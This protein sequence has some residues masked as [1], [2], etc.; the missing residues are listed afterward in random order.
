MLEPTAA[1]FLAV[2]ET[3]TGKDGMERRNRDL[4]VM[5]VQSKRAPADDDYPHHGGQLHDAEGFIAGFVDALDIGAPEVRGDSDGD[6]HG[7]PGDF[8]GVGGIVENDG[9]GA[10]LGEPEHDFTEQTQD[11]LPGSDGADRACEHVIEHQCAD[12]Q[13]GEVSTDGAFDDLVHTAAGEHR[14]AFDI[15]RTHGIAEEHDPENEP[16][17]GFADGLLADSTDVVGGACQIAEHDGGR[18]QKLMKLSATL[19]TRSTLV[20]FSRSFPGS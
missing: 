13:L 8:A 11:I 14:A 15:Y 1:G 17:G 2:V 10:V 6:E 16:G 7:Q 20:L 18:A 3:S 19:V 12:R 5:Q 9:M 4:R